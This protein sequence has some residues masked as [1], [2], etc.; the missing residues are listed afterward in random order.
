MTLISLGAALTSLTSHSDPIRSWGTD[1]PPTP[2]ALNFTLTRAALLSGDRKWLHTWPS[3]ET[4]SPN[5]HHGSP[6]SLSDRP[7]H[8]AAPPHDQLE[9][10]I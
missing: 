9:E 3:T 5:I 1:T 6:P 4:M 10:V 2:S 8:A 7:W